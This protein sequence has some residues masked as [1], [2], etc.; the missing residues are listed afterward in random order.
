[1]YLLAYYLGS[2]TFGALVG[3]AYQYG[4]WRAAAAAIATLFVLG[5]VTVLGI[6]PEGVLP[7]DVRSSS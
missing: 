6:G 7:T 5:A 2:S 3:P 4:G 1:M